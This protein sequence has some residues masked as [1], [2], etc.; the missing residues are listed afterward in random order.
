MI[1]KS[2]IETIEEAAAVLDGVALSLRECSTIGPDNNDWKQIVEQLYALSER[3]KEK[4][5]DKQCIGSSEF[6]ASQVMK[7]AESE[8]VKCA[9]WF[10]SALSKLAR[11]QPDMLVSD[12]LRF[13]SAAMPKAALLFKDYVAKT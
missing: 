4:R 5:N 11:T 6:L 10:I 12:V 7:Q 8:N 9:F 3:M 2:D 1:Q 13:A